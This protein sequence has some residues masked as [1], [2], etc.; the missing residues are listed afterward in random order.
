MTARGSSVT[1]TSLSIVRCE[2][3]VTLTQHLKPFTELPG[4]RGLP[5]IGTLWDYA[6]PNGLRLDKL[7]E[8]EAA[9]ID[10]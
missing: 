3:T 4:P 6:K 10:D 7:F 1:K 2:S 5:L 9:S 8:V